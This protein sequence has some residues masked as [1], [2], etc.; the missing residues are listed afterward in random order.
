MDRYS[1]VLRY[2]I[3]RALNMLWA[4]T[5]TCTSWAQTKPQ[6]G[7]VGSVQSPILGWRVVGNWKMLGEGEPVFFKT[8]A[9]VGQPCSNERAHIQEYT[10]RTSC[11]FFF[12][13][14]NAPFFVIYFWELYFNFS[15]S[16]IHF[17]P[18]IPSICPSPLIYSLFFINCY[19]MH[20][21]AHIHTYMHTHHIYI[22]KYNLLSSYYVT[23]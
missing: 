17:L 8:V 20:V 18:P 14:K 11:L 21:C 1:E 2:I 4:H 15:I 12:F 5:K 13:K 23:C 6:Q 10:N 22:P 9:L 3:L 19:C 7:E 16:S